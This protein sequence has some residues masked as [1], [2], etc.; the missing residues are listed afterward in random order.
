MLNVSGA[1]GSE[2]KLIIDNILTTNLYIPNWSI[3]SEFDKNL[4]E[5]KVM[6]KQINLLINK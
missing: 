4:L 5:Y 6:N 3:S 2:I 1:P